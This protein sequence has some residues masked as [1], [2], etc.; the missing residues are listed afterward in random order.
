VLDYPKAGRKD[1][2]APEQVFSKE[3][4]ETMRGAPLTRLHPTDPDGIKPSNW[5]QHAIGHVSDAMPEVDQKNGLVQT[6]VLVSDADVLDEIDRDEL[7]EISMGYDADLI[8]DEGE[9]DG[10]PYTHRQENIRYNHAAI[11]PKGWGRAGPTVAIQDE[12]D[13]QMIKL[14]LDGKETEFPSEA[15]ALAH[16]QGALAA[17]SSA[18]AAEKKAHEATKTKLKDA[19]DPKAISKLVRERTALMSVARAVLGDSADD[20]EDADDLEV[21]RKVI[22]KSG[23]SLPKDASADYIQGAYDVAAKAHADDEEGGEGQ[24][25]P[26]DDEEETAPVAPAKTTDGRDFRAPPPAGRT[27]ARG[28]VSDGSTELAEARA[29][30]LAEQAKLGTS[31]DG[32]AM[33][34][35]R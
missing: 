25:P 31:T 5:K 13:T 9:A 23:M 7:G 15:A 1:Y 4:L 35:G 3:S 14:I 19:A 24:E 12:K 21:K 20:L 32:F 27:V 22:A 11:G 18:H 10:E 29:R 28:T 30:H 33:V 6:E 8:E 2:R 26:E 17:V 34:K 16:V